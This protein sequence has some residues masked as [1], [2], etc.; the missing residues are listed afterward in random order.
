MRQYLVRS[1]TPFRFLQNSQDFFVEEIPLR[2]FGDRGRCL[3]I[4]IKKENLST[5]QL[6]DIF[7]HYFQTKIGYAGLK[8]KNATTIQ[9]ISL[10]ERHYKALKK[11][12]H[13]KISI[14]SIQ[15][16][17][18]PLKMGDL[19]GNRFAINI[20][21][22][23]EF[24]KLQA[25]LQKIIKVGVPNYFGYQRFGRDGLQKAK[26]FIEEDY[27]TKNKRVQKLLGSIYQSDLFNRWLQHRV[28]ISKKGFLKLP[29]DV[30]QKDEKFF[31]PKEVIEDPSW[32][33]TG[34]LPGKGAFRARAKAREIEKRYDADL[35]FRGGRRPALFYP[36][37][38]QVQKEGS[39]VTLQ[40]TL[41]KGSYATILL[42]NI[43]GKELSHKGITCA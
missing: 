42:E 39:R 22:V 30:Y 6:L 43:A 9:Y 31:T 17:N 7:S 3:I 40:F 38:L 4:K 13:A 33:V 2:P 32:I 15:K 36:K 20:Y 14:L 28:S 37:D 27:F 12:R 34:L 26:E 23:K 8:D 18:K 16:S 19:L 29:G 25:I 21:N 10:D 41:P 11:F 35:P 5:W 1:H 24:D